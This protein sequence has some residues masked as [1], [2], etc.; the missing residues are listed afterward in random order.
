MQLP[1]RGRAISLTHVVGRIHREV[2]RGFLEAALDARPADDPAAL[3]RAALIGDAAALTALLDSGASVDGRDGMG[4]TPLMEAAFA[5]HDEAVALLLT[6]GADPN[7]TDSAGWTALM[8]AA[9]K[10][11]TEIVKT[12]LECGANPTYRNPGGWSALRATPRSQIEILQLLKVAGAT[13]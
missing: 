13:H 2:V 11:R 6:R 7:A 8:E 9:S 3:M 10:G 12:L 5:G 1:E 4:R